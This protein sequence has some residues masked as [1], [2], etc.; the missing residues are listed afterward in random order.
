MNKKMAMETAIKIMNFKNTQLLNEST[1]AILE[2]QRNYR[3]NLKEND[4]IVVINFGGSNLDI[5]CCEIDSKKSIRIIENGGNSNLGGNIFDEILMKII[6]EKILNEYEEI[7]L[8]NDDN[9]EMNYYF[10]GKND[11]KLTILQRNKKQRRINRLRRESERIKIELSYQSSVEISLYNLFG[12][13]YDEDEMIPI[14]ITR[15][16]FEEKCKENGIYD[17]IKETIT[18][19]S[20]L[21]NFNKQ[22]TNLILLIG[23]T[24]KIPSVREVIF[25]IF[26][27][28]KST[29]PSF[30]VL[31]SVV[32]GASYYAYTSLIEEERLLSVICIPIGIEIHN[33]MFDV[34][35]KT[36]DPIPSKMKKNYTIFIENRKSIVFKIYSGESKYTTSLDMKCID[37]LRLDNLPNIQ[38]MN[39]EITMKINENGSLEM[40]VENKEYSISKKIITNIEF[41][42]ESEEI[43]NL[44]NHVSQ[45]WVV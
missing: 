36:G 4:K 20:K 40:K 27:K 8:L 45:F 3:N 32:K 33:R 10:D 23:G 44:R 39:V 21:S 19:I 14:E 34:F 37:R 24:C 38:K 29:D 6:K 9:E 18:K 28:Y 41:K 12:D 42:N 43:I 16:E 30:D 11:D 5:S 15:N 25:T 31:T 1:A 22:N 17:K 2:Y 7:L 35:F 13:D 26:D